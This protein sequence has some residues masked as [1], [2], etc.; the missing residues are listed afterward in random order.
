MENGESKKF[1]K[2]QKRVEEL[3]A[4]YGHLAVYLFI[5]TFITLSK[6]VVNMNNGET[7][8]ESLWDFGT[9]AVWFFWG[10]GLMFHA[11]KVF[12]FNPLFGRNWEKKQIKKYM[13]ED[14]KEAKKYR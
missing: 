4:F 9:F 13:E 5:N 10:I 14:E 7:L 12:S 3:K 8:G 11:L 1:K 2:A 6:V